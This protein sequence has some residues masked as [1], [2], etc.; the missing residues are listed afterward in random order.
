MNPYAGEA[1][2]VMRSPI[3][4]SVFATAIVASAAAHA[5]VLATFKKV[6]VSTGGP[7]TEY[8]EMTVV[9]EAPQ[10]AP[11]PEGSEFE[12]GKPLAE[13]YATH[14]L[15]GRRE[16]AARE[17]PQ[18]QPS[19]SLDPVGDSLT[20]DVPSAP[21]GEG[22]MLAPAVPLPPAP[23]LPPVP[24][25]D[26]PD[27]S[28]RLMLPVADRVAEPN[29]EAP[30]VPEIGRTE[31]DRLAV[32]VAPPAVA[33]PHVP[34]PP[35]PAPVPTPAPGRGGGADPAPQSDSESDAF[36]VLGGVEFR[37]GKVTVQSGRRVKTRR[38][39]VG[40]AGMVELAHRG[41]ARVE[42]KVSVDRTGKVTNVDVARSSGSNDIDQPCRVAMYDWWFEPKKDAAGRAVPD[43]FLFTLSFR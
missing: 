43:Q 4:M 6:Q 14:D 40:L 8:A 41:T 11:A 24:V 32:A 28:V 33:A 36:S 1:G 39:K 2:I 5:L 22:A 23:A 15:S 30:V 21:G 37:A 27:R 34:A 25:P 7:V 9:Y 10:T 18:D 13:G 38:P 42:L 29:P 16:Q 31:P 35:H 20:V 17:A 26:G 19:L 3:G 12:I